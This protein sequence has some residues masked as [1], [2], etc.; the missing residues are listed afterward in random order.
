MTIEPAYFQLEPKLFTVGVLDSFKINGLR[1][2]HFDSS[3]SLQASPVPLHMCGWSSLD[4]FLQLCL[5]L[6][7]FI[8]LQARAGEVQ[9]VSHR[10][11]VLQA[12][13]GRGFLRFCSDRTGS[14]SPLQFDHLGSM[15]WSP[16]SELEGVWPEQ[17]HHVPDLLK[18]DTLHTLVHG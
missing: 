16:A 17:S 10:V 3:L 14:V 2:C 4:G 9:R 7:R 8:V 12:T 5:L 1:S 11:F 18:W 6:S 13:N 15:S